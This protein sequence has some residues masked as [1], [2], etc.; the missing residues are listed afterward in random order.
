MRMGKWS[1]DG[2]FWGIHRV[3]D[4]TLAHGAN[5]QSSSPIA[6]ERLTSPSLTTRRCLF[7]L[8]V[9]LEGRLAWLPYS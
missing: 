9:E 3:V 5:G 1:E 8:A 4:N 6:T 2:V 7:K